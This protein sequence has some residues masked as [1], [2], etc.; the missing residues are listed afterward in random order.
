MAK[1]DDLTCKILG[2]LLIGLKPSAIK[3]H[4]KPIELNKK[5]IEMKEIRLIDYDLMNNLIFKGKSTNIK[6][7]KYGRAEAENLKI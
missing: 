4:K 7:T 5:L 3:L 6:L 1:Y 2:R